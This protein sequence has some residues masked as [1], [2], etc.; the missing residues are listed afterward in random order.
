MI[1]ERLGNISQINKRIDDETKYTGIILD[2][3]DYILDQYNESMYLSSV[4]E[5]LA[6]IDD[7]FRLINQIRMFKLNIDTPKFNANST[8]LFRIRTL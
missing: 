5:H 8:H 2:Q 6:Q 7:H 4:N 1:N 3:Q